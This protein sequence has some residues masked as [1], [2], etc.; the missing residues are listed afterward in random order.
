MKAHNEG[1]LNREGYNMTYRSPITS[2][3]LTSKP[4]ANNVKGVNGFSINKIE[5]RHV[6]KEKEVTRSY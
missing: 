5:R 4:T 6:R 2:R 1:S 3:S